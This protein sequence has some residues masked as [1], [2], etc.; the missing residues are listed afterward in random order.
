[1]SVT[2]P[3]VLSAEQFAVQM[4]RPLTKLT[5]VLVPITG[6]AGFL[7]SRAHWDGPALRVLIMAVISLV[8]SCAYYRNVY[9][10]GLSGQITR[11]WGSSLTATG[12]FGPLLLAIYLTF[13]EG[14]WGLRTLLVSFSLSHTVTCLGFI[15]LGY[16][17]AVWTDQLT[18]FGE[19][20]R[21]GR[22]VV[23][24]RNRSVRSASEA[25]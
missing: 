8:G 13:Y 12:A 23:E 16:R 2:P 9:K 24:D 1:M 25:A 4:G 21:T 7:A 10:A 6:V 19:H 17:L 5:L 18:Q 20:V 22:L 3:L 14:I 15:V 11:S